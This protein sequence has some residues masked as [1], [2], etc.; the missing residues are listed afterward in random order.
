[1]S[2]MT[3]TVLITIE[4]SAFSHNRKLISGAHCHKT[5]QFI[6]LDNSTVKIKLHK[7][8]L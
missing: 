3:V 6:Y 1:M 7:K 4:I 8:P 5:K 2:N